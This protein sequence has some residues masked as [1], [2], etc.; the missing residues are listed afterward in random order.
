MAQGTQVRIVAGGA[1]GRAV[2]HHLRALLAYAR[3]PVEV[4]REPMRVP[5][6]RFVAGGAFAVRAAWRDV[7]A[8]FEAFATAA[9]Q[10]RVP[11]L[12][13]AMGHPYLRVGPAVVP[14][15]SPCH[16]CYLT[17]ARQHGT[18]AD[19]AL[20]EAMTADDKLGVRG[21]PPHLS[22]LAAGLALSL[23]RDAEAGRAGR[24]MTIDTRTDEVNSWR[25]VPCHGCPGCDER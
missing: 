17:R 11:W 15:V 25:V 9:G 18:S 19:P 13:V 22:M 23:I 2:A 4:A 1:F 10:A 21:F 6:G 24:I 8:E 3:R 20:E 12:P 14:G 5:P 7:G 16:A